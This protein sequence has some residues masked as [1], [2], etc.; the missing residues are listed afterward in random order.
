M[1]RLTKRCNG[2]V[3]YVGSEMQNDTGD[4]PCE[5]STQGVREIL[6]RLAEYEDTRLSPTGCAAA[7]KADELLEKNGIQIA[8]LLELLEACEEGRIV[9]LPCKVGDTVYFAYAKHILEFTVVG[10]AVDE[11]GISWVHSEH[12]DKIGNT[13]E[14]TFSPD[15]FGKNTFLS[16]EEAEKTLQEMEGRS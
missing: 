16:R 8:A 4:I 5:V 1:E 2:I 12:V 15:R 10:Y 7:K 9:V 13:N 14:R 11:T 3:A 6:V